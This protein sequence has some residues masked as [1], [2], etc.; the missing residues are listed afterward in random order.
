MG[1]ICK[2]TLNKETFDANV[3]DLLLDSA[4][5]SGVD[6]QHDC[7][8]G[9]CGSCKVRL[10]DGKVFGGTEDGSDMIYAC[11][12]RVVSDIKIVTEKVPDQVSISAEIAELVRLAPDTFGVTLELPKPLRYLPGQYCNLQFRG[13][14]IRSYSPTYP[15]EGGPDDR[16]LH[17]HIR[18]YPDGLVSSAMGQKIRRGHKVKV[19][20]PLG[21][22]FFRRKQPGRTILVAGGTGFAPMWSIAVAAITERPQR[23][24]VAIVATRKLQSFYMHRALCRLARFPNVTIIP[25]ISEP[26]N[27]SQAFRSGRPTE[28]IPANLTPDDMVYTCGAPGMT[29]A[30]A[31][32][33]RA[34]GAKCYADPFVSH[35]KTTEQ[36]SLR[37]RL[38]SWIDPQRNAGNAQVLRV[39]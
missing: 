11:Q 20:G 10:V 37:T 36:V 2:V 23:E 15:L 38:A 26:Q 16:L 39:A 13:F 8:S 6:I 9:V 24:M 22:A 4:I 34:A 19:M 18:R 30:V 1:K 3:G 28:Y 25:V 14:P 27:V 21:T 5:M 29:D 17:F 32:I 35:A 7:R 33:A 12:A 31:K